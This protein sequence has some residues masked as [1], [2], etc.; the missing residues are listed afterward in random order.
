L[1]VIR[2]RIAHL[3]PS[4]RCAADTRSCYARGM[5]ELPRFWFGAPPQLRDGE[6]WVAHHAANRTQG[7]RA[8]GGGLH[9][10]TQRLLFSPNVIDSKLGGQRWECALGEIE[11][12]GVEPGKFRIMELFS[13]GLAARLRVELTDGRKELFVISAPEQRVAE[14]LHLL[15]GVRSGSGATAPLPEARV[16]KPGDR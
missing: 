4:R 16:V 15:A 6:Q 3:R 10:T 2:I 8:V 5:S 11:T 14:L 7:R 1:R 9:F 13:G 12:L